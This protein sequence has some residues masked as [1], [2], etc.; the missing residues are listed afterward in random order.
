M[1]AWGYE[2]YDNDTALDLKDEFELELNQTDKKKIDK[3]LFDL[4]ESACVEYSEGLFALADLYM[5]N[6]VP[7]DIIFF[8]RILSVLNLEITRVNDWDEP[9]KRYNVLVDFISK[10]T[11]YYS[12]SLE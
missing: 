11:I 12:K 10:I 3:I 1:G 9:S 6:K 2:I 4:R 7:F 8:M 5:E